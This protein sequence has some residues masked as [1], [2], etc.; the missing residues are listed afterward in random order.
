LERK[1]QEEYMNFLLEKTQIVLFTSLFTEK[2]CLQVSGKNSHYGTDLVIMSWEQFQWALFWL[3]ILHVICQIFK[4]IGAIQS[5]FSGLN[6][7]RHFN[8][9][10]DSTITWFYNHRIRQ[11]QDSTITGF[12]NHRIRQSQ[13]STIGD[14]FSD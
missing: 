14:N 9:S 6:I 7:N 8:Q 12:D 3:N 10:Q 2:R 5:G 1:C 11:S 13:D 4:N